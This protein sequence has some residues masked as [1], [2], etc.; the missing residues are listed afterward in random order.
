MF[1]TASAFTYF[2]VTSCVTPPKQVQAAKVYEVQADELATVGAPPPA[3][4]ATVLWTGSEMIIWGGTNNAVNSMQASRGGRYNSEN[5]TWKSITDVYAPHYRFAHSAIWTGSAMLVWGGEALR[6]KDE[7]LASGGLYDPAD[8]HWK[9]INIKNAPSPRS[10]HTTVWASSYKKMLVW[11][12]IDNE[13]VL[14]NG[15]IYSPKKNKWVK[16]PGKTV[17]FKKSQGGEENKSSLDKLADEQAPEAPKPADSEKE[18]DGD[19]QDKSEEPLAEGAPSPR[20]NH[21]A[22][23]T[24]SEMIIWGGLGSDEAGPLGDGARLSLKNKSW[25]PI[26]N[27]GAP[28]P[29]YGHSAVWTGSKMIVWGGWNNS[30]HLDDGGIYDP[31]KNSWKP[32]S[33]IAAPS[34]RTLHSAVLAD[35]KMIIF[36]GLTDNNEVK[37]DGAIYDIN[38]NKWYKLLLKGNIEGRYLHTAINTGSAIVFWGGQAS[39][40]ELVKKGGL[41]IPLSEIQEKPASAVDSKKKMSKEKGEK[42]KKVKKAKKKKVTQTPPPPTEKKT[43]KTIGDEEIPASMD[44]LEEI[45]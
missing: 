22:L 38:E 4:S 16:I 42:A 33:Q 5:D 21:V 24:G 17:T 7:K 18:E 25:T 8:D 36:G 11:G 34:A 9:N 32:L 40:N 26:S 10:H 19:S 41:V 20:S 35:H 28:S 30:A 1:F 37:D 45:E 12:G 2:F 13:N 39:T 3:E 29:R 44:A 27:A 23:W 31:K 14:G 15:G 43:I 6:R